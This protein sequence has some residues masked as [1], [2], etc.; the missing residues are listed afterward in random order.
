MKT[1]HR[2]RAFTLV[3][4]LVVIGIIALL[5]GI[6]MPTLNS[7]RGQARSVACMSNVRQIA[8]AGIMYAQ[9]T[10]LYVS[11]VPAVGPT[12]AKD[13]KEL[14]YPY[15][16]QGKNNGDNAGSQ[17]WNCPS[18]DR[19]DEQAS[20]GF[21]TYVN[22]VRLNKIKMWSETIAIVDA[23][24]TDTPVGGS[25]LAT[26]CW[27]PSRIATAASCRPNHLRHPKQIVTAG[28]VDGHA[29]RLPM[30]PPFYVGRV[31]TFTPN[32]ITVTTDPNYS[33]KLWDLN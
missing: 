9:E 7:A 22:G 31:G 8:T 23:G 11:F 4:L 28:F 13:R 10:K 27:P 12:P 19:V 18:N 3:E 20:Y 25:S 26:H 1:L 2:P 33:D 6:L 32:G 30:K 21:N 5:M 24:L 14:L 15:L 29:E 17:V 16:R